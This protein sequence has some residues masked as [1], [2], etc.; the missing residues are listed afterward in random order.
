MMVFVSVSSAVC[1]PYEQE[2]P[3]VINLIYLEL[4]QPKLL[5]LL[6]SGRRFMEN[7][8]P[9]PSHD[10]TFSFG[11][12]ICTQL[13]SDLFLKHPCSFFYFVRCS[14]FDYFVRY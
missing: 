1:E 13:Y 5:Q 4:Q 10:P 6:H 9:Y 14:L 12:G 7:P 2:L 3:V 8:Y 11:S